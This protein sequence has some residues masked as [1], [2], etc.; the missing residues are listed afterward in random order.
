MNLR[1]KI[2]PLAFSLLAFA[3][4]SC[5][6]EKVE[7]TRPPKQSA[8]RSTGSTNGVK[9]DPKLEAAVERVLAK[10]FLKN[11]PGAAVLVSS[12]GV[13]RL[14]KCYGL[15]N[16]SQKR[17]ITTASVFDLASLSKQFTATAALLL[18]SQGKLSLQTPVSR[19]LPDF[20]VPIKGRPITVGDLIYQISGLADYTDD[21]DWDRSDEEFRHLT[22]EGH[23]EWLNGTK[24]RRAPGRKWEYNNSNYALLA[25]V[26]E[27]TAGMPFAQFLKTRLFARAG[28]NHT[29][30]HDK[31]AMHQTIPDLVMGYARDAKKVSK[32][33]MWTQ[34]VGD[35]NVLTTIEDIA[36]WDRAL[37]QSTILNA[38]QKKLAW[39]SG[40][41]DNGKEIS[42]EG[43]GYGFGWNTE[44]DGSDVFHSGSWMG[45]STYMIRYLKSGLTIVVL[46]NDEN[47]EAGGIA[48][49]IENAL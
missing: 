14:E 22:L 1:P 6:S 26:V 49:E 29:T 16:I 31:L 41:L 4:S 36:A 7:G 17:P 24:P 48:S 32:S 30:I 10:H 43:T 38:V 15:A 28:M 37:R 42:D 34:L 45:T 33:A 44:P 11:G 39:T 35:G 8:F 18:I 19:V 27:K 46:S 47:A 5:G 2:A 3:L 40:H 12:N 9:A 23:L 20:Q 21:S 13:V 25:L